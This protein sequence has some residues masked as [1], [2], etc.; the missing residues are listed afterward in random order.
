MNLPECFKLLELP[1]NTSLANVRAAYLELVKVW[2]PDRFPGDIAL[3]TRAQEKLKQINI[4]YETIVKHSESA[5]AAQHI[6]P[7]PMRHHRGHSGQTALLQH[8]KG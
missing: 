4:A 2:H 7:Q 5:M 1:E 3:Q 6:H 8:L